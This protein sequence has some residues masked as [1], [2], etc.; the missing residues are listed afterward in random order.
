MDQHNN[1]PWSYDNSAPPPYHDGGPFNHGG[2]FSNDGHYNHHRRYQ[3]NYQDVA[4][5]PTDS[6]GHSNGT[7]FSGRKRP[8]SHSGHGPTDYFD[9]DKC[10]KLY[11]SG[12]PK[13]ASEEDI[14]SLFGKHGT[15]IEVI[16]FKQIKNLQQQD[17]CFVKYAKIEDASQAIRAL[18]NQYTFPGRMRPIEVKYATKKQERPGPGFLKA[19]TNKV[20]VCFLNKHASR[21]EIAEIFSP[22]GCVEEVYLIHDDPRRIRGMG[23]IT[24]SDKVMAADA[25]NGL[26]G[27]YQMKGCDQPLVVRFADPKKP[28]IW[29]NRSSPYFSDPVAQT[30]LPNSSQMS[31]VSSNCSMPTCMDMEGPPDCEWSEHICPDGNEYYYNCVTCESLWEKPEVYSLYEQQLENCNQQSDPTWA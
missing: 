26:N 18:H 31:S 24:F 2:G 6:F 17:C 22:Y 21:A 5:E 13:E 19:P 11:V 23:F 7:A 28:K 4:S 1:S 20:F 29:E 30:S 12:V 3:K 8:F 15:I 16:F 27:K 14:H 9:V 25:I 10:N